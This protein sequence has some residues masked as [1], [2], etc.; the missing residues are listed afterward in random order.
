[1]TGDDG[2][3]S[4]GVLSGVANWLVG[5]GRVRGLTE[6]HSLHAAAETCFTISLAGSIFFS[7]SADAARP[8][9][10]LY[11]VITLAPFL[12]MAPLV[13]PVI[14]RVRGGVGRGG[15]RNVPGG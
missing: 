13:G 8:R 7:V 2:S 12:V 9:V 11:L 15:A 10:L 5:S 3:R 1:M 14:D 4:F 6:M